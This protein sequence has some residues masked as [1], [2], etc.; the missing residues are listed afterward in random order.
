MLLTIEAL[1]FF[2]FP[3]LS[4][5]QEQIRTQVNNGSFP[6]NWE[7]MSKGL[8]ITEDTTKDRSILF[9]PLEPL[10]NERRGMIQSVIY[11]PKATQLEMKFKV[12]VEKTGNIINL[13]INLHN[14]NDLLQTDSLSLDQKRIIPGQWNDFSFKVHDYRSALLQGVNL[15][16]FQL[17]VA[18]N[19]K[20]WIKDIQICTN[21]G[22]YKGEN[23]VPVF[24]ADADDQ[25][26]NGSGVKSIDLRNPLIIQNLDILGRVWGFMKYYH[27]AVRN[28]SFNWDYELFKILPLI[29]SAKSAQERNHILNKWII[30]FAYT[31]HKKQI[32]KSNDYYNADFSWISKDMLGDSLHDAVNE[33]KHL[34]KDSA[35]YYLQYDNDMVIPSHENAYRQM[36]F[37]DPGFRLLAAFRLW[38]HINYFYAYKGSL[39][40]SWDKQM[41][42]LIIKFL[43]V[44]DEQQYFLAFLSTLSLF[45]NSHVTVAGDERAQNM[46]YLFWGKNWLPAQIK[47]IKGKGYVVKLSAELQGIS[48]GIELGDQIISV[49]GVSI[50][51]LIAN[52]SNYL[53]GSNKRSLERD[54]SLKL[55]RTNDTLMNLA[56]RRKRKILKIK[57]RKFLIAESQ[58]NAL[59]LSYG[60]DTAFT[61]LKD[62]IGYINISKISDTTLK[63]STNRLLDTR[64]L[65]LDL[66]GYPIAEDVR[67]FLSEHF[68]PKKV[69]F[70]NYSYADPHLPGAVLINI[71][72]IGKDNPLYYKQKVIVLVN[73]YTQSNPEYLTMMCRKMPNSLI[74]GSAT[75]GADGN[76]SPLRL[77]GGLITHFESIGIYTPDG[78]ETQGVGIAP[79]HLVLPDLKQLVGKTDFL[80]EKSMDILR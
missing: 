33:L 74:I 17:I 51:K 35:S 77:P 66:R 21:K 40:F 10:N 16:S 68:F 59:H 41:I 9:S 7:I 12:W 56:V 29:I 71:D 8:N 54:Y 24:Q 44:K 61:I 43:D 52:R 38:N 79:D 47:F 58:I 25:F 37:P 28:G 80:I 67:S 46:E 42:P 34:K 62:N 50:D 4:T 53:Y 22:I 36:N 5:A 6:G 19:M 60:I 70:S 3:A 55:F 18:G 39:K 64:A 69:A 75:T 13:N 32:D 11:A 31:D 48:S 78:H 65:I 1:L 23:P 45:K 73:E 26:N 15:V 63:L 2:I 49:N 57:I 76:L 30:S 14:K 27:P 72:S 20:L